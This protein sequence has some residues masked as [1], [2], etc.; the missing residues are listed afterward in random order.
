MELLVVTVGDFITA[1]I[2]EALDFL[3]TDSGSAPHTVE[4]SSPENLINED[5]DQDTITSFQV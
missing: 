1:P 4:V 3:H 5:S 2:Y